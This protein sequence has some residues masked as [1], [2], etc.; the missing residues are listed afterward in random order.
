MEDAPNLRAVAL[1]GANAGLSM[2]PPAQDG[3]KRP[4]AVR[5][6]GYD[7]P[8][9]KHRQKDAASPG[10]ILG[11]YAAGYLE[12]TP[13]GGVHWF[14]RCVELGGNQKLALRPGADDRGRPNLQTLI[15][16]K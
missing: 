6:E 2:W 13:N 5:V 9:W 8:T 10:E 3:T 4:H 11:L 15:E 1:A 12:S 16:T 7:G 14:F